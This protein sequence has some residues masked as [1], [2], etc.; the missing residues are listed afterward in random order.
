ML[1]DPLRTEIN[2]KMD[3]FASM[4]DR[5][6]VVVAMPLLYRLFFFFFSTV[7][8]ERGGFYHTPTRCHGG[9]NRKLL[10]NSHAKSSTTEP[11]PIGSITL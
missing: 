1:K 7:S 4:H 9:S 5:L 11:D 8:K 10:I 3:G 2:N 6:S